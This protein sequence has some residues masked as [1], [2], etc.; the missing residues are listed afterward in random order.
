MEQTVEEANFEGKFVRQKWGQIET[1]LVFVTSPM[2]G[3]VQK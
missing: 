1:C 2:L 3:K